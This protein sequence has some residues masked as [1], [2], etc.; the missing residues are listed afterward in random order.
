MSENLTERKAHFAF[1]GN[2][3]DFARTVTENQVE[4]ACRGL[5]RLLPQN[6][7]KGKSFL[8]I[9]SGSGLHSVAALRLGASNVLAVDIDVESVATTRAVL[10]RFA[11]GSG[12]QVKQ[13]SVFD[14]ILSES[15][16][17]D[18]VYFWGVLHHTG[19]LLR[20]IRCAAEMVGQ[21]GFFVAVY[22]RRIWT[23]P[24]WLREK[25]WYARASSDTQARARTIFLN[26]F[27]LGLLP[28]RRS[29]AQYSAV[30][31]TRRGMSFEHEIHDWMGGWPYESIS[32]PE[33]EDLMRSLGFESVFAK[34]AARN[35]FRD[36]F[37][38][39]CD[40]YVY[41]RKAEG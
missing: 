6:A 17:F 30:Y 39:G 20:T 33:V 41:Q 8:Y 19:D 13:L 28:S 16:R 1:G 38:S 4:E 14:L 32:A 22:Y 24:F 21:D 23:D 7:I 11:S 2:W 18:I 40:E 15:E 31:M 9:G 5:L 10:E 35:V 37:R 26:L 25:R 34:C 29:P 36:H 3:A 12:S 27:R